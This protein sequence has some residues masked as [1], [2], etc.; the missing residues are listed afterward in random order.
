MNKAFEYRYRTECRGSK[1][2]ISRRLSHYL[3]FVCPVASLG[4]QTIAVDLSCGR[5]EGLEFFRDLGFDAVGID[6]VADDAERLHAANFKFESAEP[7]AWLM[8]AKSDSFGVV[9]SLDLAPRVSLDV[10][11]A[12]VREAFRVLKP[13][14]LLILQ[15]PHP[16]ALFRT[17]ETSFVDLATSQFGLLASPSLLPA[18]FEYSGFQKVKSISLYEQKGGG[19]AKSITLLDVLSGASPALGVVGQ[20]IDSNAGLAIKINAFDQEYGVSLPE[21]AD[22]FE[23]RI[24]ALEE[25][26]RQSEIELREIHDSYLWKVTAPLRWLAQ[27]LNQLKQEGVRVRFHA[28]GLK[29]IRILRHK[30]NPSK[31]P[32]QSEE[33]HKQSIPIAL[34]DEARR[35]HRRVDALS[36]EGEDIYRDLIARNTRDRNQ[37]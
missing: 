25:S 31:Y 30:W 37:S 12:I 8:A 34:E 29:V 19:D 21:L 22:Y 5:G 10:L 4:H 36:R 14:G 11:T 33:H 6:E 27:Q 23:K 28:F 9:F 17:R 18:V 1:D 26:V 32:S 16:Q 15:Q 13:G 24:C 7:L 2:E 35:T 3:P 20:K